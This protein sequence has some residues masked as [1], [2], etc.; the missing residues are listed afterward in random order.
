MCPIKATK[1][2]I[3]NMTP[4][5]RGRMGTHAIRVNAVAPTYVRTELIGPS[6]LQD[7]ELIARIEAM[8]P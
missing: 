4:R 2:A 7:P 8:T 6:I 3:V 5:A 1:G